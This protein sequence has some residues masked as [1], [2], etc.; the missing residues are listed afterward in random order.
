MSFFG[1]YCPASRSP[2]LTRPL[3]QAAEMD[4]T[5]SAPASALPTFQYQSGEQQASAYSHYSHSNSLPRRPS[6]QPISE[7]SVYGTDGVSTYDPADYVTNFIEPSAPSLLANP[8]NMRLQVGQLTPDSKWHLPLDGDI[9]PA[10]LSAGVM[11]PA[12]SIDGSMSRQ[13]SCNLQFSM[14]RVRSDSSNNVPQP[15]FYEDG[16][17]IS[18]PVD[19]NNVTNISACA[20]DSFLSSFSGSS[21]EGFS[22]SAPFYSSASVLELSQQPSDLGE[23]LQRS[24]STSSNESD[25]SYGSSS[26][27]DSRQSRRDREINAQAARKLAPKLAATDDHARSSNIQIKTVISAD[28]SSKEVAPIARAAQNRPRKR[29]KLN[30]QYCNNVFRGTHELERHTAR[31]HADVRKGFICIDFWAEKNFLSNCKHCRNKKVYNAYY[32]AAAHLR[33]THFHPRQRVKKGD[34]GEKR[35]GHGGGD[36]PPMDY[37]RKHWIKEIEVTGP[38]KKK[39]G[40]ENSSADVQRDDGHD[41]T[42]EDNSL[43]YESMDISYVQQPNDMPDLD[44]NECMAPNVFMSKDYDGYDDMAQFN[45]YPESLPMSSSTSFDFDF[46]AYQS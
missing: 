44:I 29:E 38:P 36:D 20:D 40:K 15:L 32:N 13:A 22:S 33:R 19:V 9:S 3:M 28:G 42:Q 35:G 21:T 12:T 30:C 7:T 5:H 43:R 23:D 45:A 14:M 27:A 2:S 1:R 37:L 11:T 4:R 17:S 31:A 18:F 25:V 34:V 6:L 10:T 46:E 24:A 8:D 39:T 26:S 41:S 16:S